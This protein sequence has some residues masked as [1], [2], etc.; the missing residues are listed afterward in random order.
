[1][2]PRATPLL[3]VCLMAFGQIFEPAQ[4]QT[5]N[6]LQECTNQSPDIDDIHACLDNY[7]DIMDANIDDV[8]IFLNRTL[9]GPSLA[10]FKRSQQAFVQYRRQNCLW[11]LEF[12]SPRSEAEQIAKN[13][14]ATMS[15][16]R[17]SELQRLMAA[18]KT[19]EKANTLRG[20]YVYGASS[21][22]FQLCGQDARYWVEGDNPTLNQI[23]QLYL[24]AATADLQIMYAVVKGELDD[25]TPTVEGHQ[26]VLR[27][28]GVDEIRVPNESDCRLPSGQAAAFSALA[29]TSIAPAEPAIVEP[30]TTVTEEQEEP[31]QQLVAYFGAW[32]ADCI[33]NDG[34]RKCN[35]QV[36][37][38]ADGSA[39]E[40]EM[41]TLSV[42]RK[43]RQRTT[44]EVRF[45]DREIDTPQ[46]I[47]WGVD[48]YVFG[49]ILGSEIRVDEAATRQL[50]NERRFINEDLMPLMVDG[51][52]LTLDVLASVDDP[53]GEKFSA[54]LRGLT[55]ALAFAD[56]FVSD[57]S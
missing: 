35:L 38:Q 46:R 8:S 39:N 23:Q 19:N 9:E 21:N 44:I 11:Y 1:M 37:M 17:L 7:L 45:P 12:S 14:L 52:K 54:T 28:A 4:A 56:E 27:L 36:D 55:R 6:V 53:T 33:E 20:F 16:Q 51:G 48:A 26:G 41:P 3:F 2:S 40:S 43:T 34:N 32:V 31:Q 18:D 50:V 57:G 42:A 22:S 29:T 25:D 15:Q 24:N 49:D 13:C 47:R 5:Y 30:E 10:G